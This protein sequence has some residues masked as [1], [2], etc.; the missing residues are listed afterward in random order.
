MHLRHDLDP[1]QRSLGAFAIACACALITLSPPAIAAAESP[2]NSAAVHA[3]ML[4]P[5]P[6]DR[7]SQAVREAD[8]ALTV[9]GDSLL[10]LT[11]DQDRP[12]TVAILTAE[13]EA[14]RAA[15]TILARHQLDARQFVL[16]SLA[17]INGY[18][19]AMALQSHAPVQGGD[20][21][22]AQLHFCQQHMAMIK[23]MYVNDGNDDG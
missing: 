7:M 19:A 1:W 8:V 9:S 22:R 2:Q 18:S 21:P 6:L 20:V 3:V 17:L 10:I 15:R 23:A 5:E 4:T 14:N 16:T 12:K 11:D 13:I